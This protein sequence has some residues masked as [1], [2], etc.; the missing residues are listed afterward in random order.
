MLGK[1]FMQIGDYANAA[2]N[3][4]AVINGAGDAGISLQADFKNVF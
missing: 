3:L 2:I 1:V 4:Q